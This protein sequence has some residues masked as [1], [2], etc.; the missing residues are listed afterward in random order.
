MLTLKGPAALS[1]FRLAKLLDRLALAD[2]R[3]LGVTAHYNHY[4]DVSAPL[5]QVH[6]QVLNQL[7]VYY[8]EPVAPLPAGSIVHEFLVLPRTYRFKI[9]TTTAY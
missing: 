5:S 9:N 8:S 1:S 6:Q 2:A 7:L 4:V 3:V